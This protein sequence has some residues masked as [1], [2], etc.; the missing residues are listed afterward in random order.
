MYGQNTPAKFKT[1]QGSVYTVLAE[2]VTRIK[3]NDPS[4]HGGDGKNIFYCSYAD[5]DIILT[6]PDL[7]NLR[8]AKLTLS[9]EDKFQKTHNIEM[10]AAP[11]I[12]LCPVDLFLNVDG[13]ARIDS[14]LHVGNKITEIL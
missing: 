12:D 2:G 1:G 10:V 5:S 7:L 9:Y 11:A 4:P 13:T 14:R 3:F 8:V 6:A